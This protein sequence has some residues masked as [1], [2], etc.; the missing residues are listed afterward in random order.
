MKNL[1]R[2]LG[3]ER[4]AKVTPAA[5]RK[6][7]ALLRRNLEAGKYSGLLEE[8]ARFYSSWYASRAR[9]LEG[10]SR[11]KKVAGRTKRAA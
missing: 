7:A 5:Y 8:K 2:K 10:T 11:R 4:L 9:Q 3:L 6:R 1:G